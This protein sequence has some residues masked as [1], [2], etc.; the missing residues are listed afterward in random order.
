ML[1]FFNPFFFEADSW[2]KFKKRIQKR[3][4]QKLWYMKGVIWILYR[5]S[6]RYKNTAKLFDSVEPSHWFII[7]VK[8]FHTAPPIKQYGLY[9][10]QN[11]TL[12]RTSVRISDSGRLSVVSIWS[13]I[14]ACTTIFR[15]KSIENCNKL[16][17]KIFKMG[18]HSSHFNLLSP[19]FNILL[20]GVLWVLIRKWP[21]SSALQFD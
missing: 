6:N 15:K 11:P 1:V 20:L 13:Q 5:Q 21:M 18:Q 10:W 9:I 16:L 3:A 7:C 14:F 19:P 4:Y 12:G 8:I 2:Y 17:L